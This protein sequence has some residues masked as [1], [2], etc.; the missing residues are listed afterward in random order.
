MISKK[1]ALKMIDIIADMFPNAECELRHN[2]AFE[3]TIA[4]LLSAQCTDNLVNKVTATL[5]TKY[6]TPEDYLAVPLEELEQ[7]IRSIG[8]YRNK[9]KNI[10]KLCTSLLE[11]FNGQIPQTHAELESLAGVGRKTANVVMSVAFGEPALAVDTHVERVSKR[12]GI[13]RWKDN[14]R[15]V[16]DRLCSIIPRDRW[17]KSHHQ[18]IFFGRYH[19]IAR[20]PK[21]DICPLFDDCREGQK[22]YKLKLKKA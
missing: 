4:V 21:C 6:K 17:N 12:L 3:L 20:K 9:A 2:N 7:D 11:K 5:F 14:V 19:C 13:N 15:Q 18:L 22:R 10:K 16:E 1:K 8:L